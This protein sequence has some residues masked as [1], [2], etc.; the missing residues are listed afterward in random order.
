MDETKLGVEDTSK[1][2]RIFLILLVSAMTIWG[3]SWSAGKAVAGVVDAGQ[4][5]F[6][7]FLLTFLSFIPVAVFSRSSLRVRPIVF[8]Q[9]TFASLFYVAYNWLFI[10]GLEKGLAGAG[11]VLVTTLNP[12][13]TFALSAILFQSALTNL[14][15]LGLI[16]GLLGGFLMLQSEGLDLTK[17]FYS[18]NLYFLLAAFSWAFMSFLSKMSRSRI[19]S[20][21]FSYYVY[22]LSTLFTLV[23]SHTTSLSQVFHH[24]ALFW[25][26]LVYLSVIS[27]TF[28][29]TVYFFA[30]ARLG[31]DRASSYIFLV[32]ATAVLGSWI[33]MSEIPQTMVLLGGALAVIAVYLINRRSS[34]R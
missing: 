30:S 4:I 17:L 19:G 34:T 3:F 24:G 16:I 21:G 2:D 13:I 25:L 28:G 14:Q 8:L 11:G 12:I 22:G 9:L 33:F 7:R 26:N 5:V 29:T 15:R 23:L 32:P 27:T 20:F 10:L 18:G 1:E 6:W 31:P